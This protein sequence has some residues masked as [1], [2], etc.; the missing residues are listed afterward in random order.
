[1]IDYVG[2]TEGYPGLPYDGIND[3]T[4]MQYINADN[5]IK[6]FNIINGKILFT[7]N[8]GQVIFY[9]AQGT[10][11]NSFDNPTSIDLS[12]IP[13]GVY[14]VTFNGTSTKFVH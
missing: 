13:H 5:S 2:G 1:M 10:E 4:G 14:I 9:N 7:G 8:C 11:I 6:T 12:S 3:P